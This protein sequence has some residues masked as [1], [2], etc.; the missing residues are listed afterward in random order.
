M[1]SNGILGMPNWL[2]RKEDKYTSPDIQK[3]ILEIMA[4]KTLREIITDVKNSGPYSVL[5]DE[6]ADV[7]NVEELV[8]CWLDR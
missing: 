2:D 6:T 3:E 8:I 5:A 7:S 4:Q 1:R